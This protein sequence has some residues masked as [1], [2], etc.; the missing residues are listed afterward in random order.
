MDIRITKGLKFETLRAWTIGDLEIKVRDF[1]EEKS[2]IGNCT[3]KNISV[4][5]SA[6]ETDNL[7]LCTILYLEEEEKESF[8]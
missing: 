1:L 8:K 4:S 7:Y 2:D 6:S 3:I 5:A